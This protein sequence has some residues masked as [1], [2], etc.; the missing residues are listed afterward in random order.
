VGLQFS[1]YSEDI[2]YIDD[3]DEQRALGSHYHLVLHILSCTISQKP[4]LF[5]PSRCNQNS[6]EHLCIRNGL[7][8]SSM[9]GDHHF[10]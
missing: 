1:E 6:T 10:F 7:F 9:I 2:E 4:H 5:R 8:S 3:I